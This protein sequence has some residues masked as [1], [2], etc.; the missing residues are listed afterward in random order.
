VYRF[1]GF[2]WLRF[3]HVP[4]CSFDMTVDRQDADVAHHHPNGKNK[5][6]PP[7]H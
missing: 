4:R 1:V 7:S 5:N 6:T 3:I 2:V